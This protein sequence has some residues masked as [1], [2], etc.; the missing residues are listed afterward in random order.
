M[1]GET[2]AVHAGT[3]LKC[4]DADRDEDEGSREREERREGVVSAGWEKGVAFK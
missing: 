4:V 3:W 2:A 1:S